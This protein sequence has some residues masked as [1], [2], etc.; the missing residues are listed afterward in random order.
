M[1]SNEEQK[2]SIINFDIDSTD[3]SSV[4]PEDPD[5]K[6]IEAQ[7]RARFKQDTLYRKYL[8]KWVMYV[9][10]IWLALVLVIFT[11]NGFRLVYYQPTV[12]IALLATT[13]ANV[14]GLAFIVLRGIFQIRVFKRKKR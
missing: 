8:A 6:D 1:N 9:V 3:V 14:L 10:S 4:T 11:L 7:E 13:T 5:E 12:M 2:Q